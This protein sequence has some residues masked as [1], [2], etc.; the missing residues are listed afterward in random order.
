MTG[1]GDVELRHEVK[2][3]AYATECESL[4]HWLRIH[5]SGFV[6]TY[7]DRQVN[8]VYFDSWDYRAFAENLAGVSRRCKL[9][10]RWYGNGDGPTT[11]SLE[12]KQKRNQLGWKQRY[13]ATQDIWSPGTDWQEIRSALRSQIPPHARF[14]FDQYPLPIMLNRYQRR[15]FVTADRRIRA[16]IDTEQQA[17]DQRQGARPNLRRPAVMQN[18]LVVEFKF[19]PDARQAAAE[20]LADI[21]FRLGRH[22]KYMNA[23]RSIAM[24]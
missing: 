7:P 15:Y 11:G 17:F 3:A 16:T 1:A 10:Y 23:L 20:L 14:W 5:P 12:V 4:C 22:S 6:K 8:N 19:A 13:A 21:P 18:T 24:A 2:F 9:R